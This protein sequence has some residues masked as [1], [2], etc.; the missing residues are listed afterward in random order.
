MPFQIGNAADEG[1]ARRGWLLGHFAEPDSALHSTDVEVKWAHHLA[2][3]RRE[4]VSS[5][6]AARTLSILVRGRFVLEFSGKEVVLAREG[7]YALWDG[8]E[9]HAWRCE[10][11]SLI[12]TVR[13]PSVP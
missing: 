3:E 9:P 1:E 7:D 5:R 13:W 6:S 11:D 2:G 4:A 12:V 10:E 8:A